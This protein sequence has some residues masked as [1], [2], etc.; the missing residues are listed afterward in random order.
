MVTIDI[1]SGQGKLSLRIVYRMRYLTWPCIGSV[2]AKQERK[3]IP[4]LS[5]TICA[6]KVKRSYGN[7]RTI[8]I[9]TIPGKFV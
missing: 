7:E 6:Q 5:H 1:L 3:S 2:Q 8:A 4:N 9:V